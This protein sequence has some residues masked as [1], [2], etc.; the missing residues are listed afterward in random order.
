VTILWGWLALAAGALSAQAAERRPFELAAGD[1]V[2]L[3]GNTFVERDL[4]HNDFETL[5][6]GRFKDRSVTFRNLGWSGDTVYGTARA[7]FGS[8][9][10]GFRRL[11]EHVAQLKPTVL[12]LAYGMNESFEGEA[13]LPRFA[14]GM[15]RLLEALLPTGARVV[16]VAPH[17][18]ENLGPPLPDPAEHNRNLRLYVEMIR[19]VALERRLDFINLFEL[20][21]P[22]PGE[23]PLTENGI[24]LSARGY[25]RAAEVMEKA[26]GLPPR[27]WRVE[28]QPQG[29]PETQGVVLS[30]L[31]WSATSVRFT[32]LDALLPG[33]E[34]RRLRV[35]GLSAG[36]FTLKIGGRPVLSGSESEWN[37]GMAIVEG[38]SFEQAER[39]RQ[40]IGLKNLF[41]FNLWRPQNETYIFGFRQKEQGHL[42]E[43]FPQ[44]DP[45]LADREARIAQ[46]RVP[47]PETYSLELRR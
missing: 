45:I 15:S 24:H 7:G 44:Y 32:A 36:T 21:V 34:E 19:K 42:R 9:E 12:F 47:V 16:L 25:R 26:L 39:L 28:L 18:H 40:A 8:A 17:R 46:L 43:E 11:R 6:S 38:P 27:A 22:G 41:Y 37:R 4:A 3:V 20:L 5:L 29:R 35:A 10:D 2:V 33:G 30:D 1:R 31:T 13:G 14:Q 23:P